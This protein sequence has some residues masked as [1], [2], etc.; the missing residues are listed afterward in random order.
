MQLE[1]VQRILPLDLGKTAKLCLLIMAA[2]LYKKLWFVSDFVEII[3]GDAKTIRFA[4]RDLNARGFV[5]IVGKTDLQANIFEMQHEKLLKLDLPILGQGTR[6][7]LA[8]LQRQSQQHRLLRSKQLK[9][10]KKAL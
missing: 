1:L 8:R 6:F 4:L 10:S 7:A 2:H 9:P 5:E 3:G